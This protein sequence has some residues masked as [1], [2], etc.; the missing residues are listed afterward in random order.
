[1]EE[2]LLL[3]HKG[4]PV[5]PVVQ[6]F[7]ED[8]QKSCDFDYK[9]LE[10]YTPEGLQLIRKYNIRSVPTTLINQKVEF[11]GVPDRAKALAKINC[12]NQKQ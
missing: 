3:T 6:S 8:L 1:M 11:V 12:A 10:V 4:C 5:C 9:R 7:W 2:V